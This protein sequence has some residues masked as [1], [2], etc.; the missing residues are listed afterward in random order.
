MSDISI[1]WEN[2]HAT[3]TLAGRNDDDVGVD[4]AG[5]LGVT[6]GGTVGAAL[7]GGL[8][9]GAALSGGLTVDAGLD[10]IRI[11]EL[12]TINTDS[13]VSIKELP[14]INTDSK[15]DLG[16]D[17]IRIQEFPPLQLELGLRPFRLHLP[18]NFKFCLE[19]LGVTL[20]KFSVCGEGMA[21]GEDYQP[22][23]TE[24]CK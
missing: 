2:I 10:E 23:E 8:A 7:S 12:A 24:R 16:L 5:G 13:A 11:K 15:V 18:V 17:N 19:V 21:I 22:K 1:P 3:L 4:V 6:L 14:Q 20:F 9:V